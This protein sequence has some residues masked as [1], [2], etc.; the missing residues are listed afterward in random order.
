M[1]W[2]KPMNKV[3]ISRPV[4]D[5][6]ACILWQVGRSRWSRSQTD[7]PTIGRSTSGEGARA[8]AYDREVSIPASRPAKLNHDIHRLNKEYPQIET[9]ET[10]V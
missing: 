10:N 7:C 1:N 5:Q 8:P 9:V 4:C 2:T 3:T 6:V